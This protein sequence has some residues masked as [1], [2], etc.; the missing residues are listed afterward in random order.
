MEILLKKIKEDK[1]RSKI[2]LDVKKE[3]TEAVELYKSF[4]FNFTGQ[5]FGRSHVMELVY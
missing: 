1:T 3:S 5:V 2:I 4:G